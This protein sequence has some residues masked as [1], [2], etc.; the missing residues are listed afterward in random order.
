MV[1]EIFDSVGPDFVKNYDT[2]RGHVREEVARF[3]LNNFLPSSQSLEIVDVGGGDG[4][5]AVWL[6]SLGHRVLLVDPS[7]EMANKAKKSIA[8]AGIESQVDVVC[9]DPESYLAE[10]HDE[11]DLVLSHGVMMYL[12][13]PHRHIELLARI[14]KVGGLVSILTRG[15]WASVARC[16]AKHDLEGIDRVMSTNRFTNNLGLDVLTVTEGS[17]EEL[18]ENSGLELLGSA[19]VR[20]AIDLDSRK[21]SEVDDKELQTIL[22]IEKRLSTEA[23]IKGLGQMLHFIYRKEKRI[24]EV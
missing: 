8:R 13:E 2:V 20:L 15:K 22:D 1:V 24:D 19:G 5:D 6:A 9:D 16:L 7:S 17:M 14:V 4:R 18:A 12:D 23:S 10:V 11:Y 3:N 21:L